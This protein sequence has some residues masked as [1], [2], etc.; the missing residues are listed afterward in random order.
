MVIKVEQS[1]NEQFHAATW[2]NLTDV[3]I[4]RGQTQKRT[5]V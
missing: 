1:K 2:L 3:L 5:I 4:E